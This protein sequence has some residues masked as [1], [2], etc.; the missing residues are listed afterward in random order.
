M[1]KI[2]STLLL[3]FVFKAYHVKAINI[4]KAIVELERKSKLAFF[5]TI[6]KTVISLYQIEISFEDLEYIIGIFPGF[7]EFKW[8]YNN[9][10]GDTDLRV[11]IPAYKNSKM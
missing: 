10:L 3:P 11:T 5:D 6:K 7:Y 9:L 1:I 2:G 4:D 8:E